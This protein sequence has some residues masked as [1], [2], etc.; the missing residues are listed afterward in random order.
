MGW[1]T[2]WAILSQTHP[3]TLLQNPFCEKH[4]SKELI[5]FSTELTG[6]RVARWFIFKPKTPIW[7]HFGGSWNGKC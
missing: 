4:F 2:F 1:A 7:V 6:A 3:V 5:G